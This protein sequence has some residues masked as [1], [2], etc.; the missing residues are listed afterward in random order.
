MGSGQAEKLRSNN[1]FKKT[2]KEY[3]KKWADPWAQKSR[4]KFFFYS[5]QYELKMPL[6]E[7]RLLSQ[8][9][10][11]PLAT[12]TCFWLPMGCAYDLSKLT[13]ERV[14]VLNRM[15]ASWDEDI[16]EVANPWIVRERLWLTIISLHVI[17]CSVYGALNWS[18]PQLYSLHSSLYSWKPHSF[19][20]Y[21]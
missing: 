8:R 12:P 4:F 2:I 10:L 7:S 9:T 17:G 11:D 13:C 5:C 15:V 14:Y 3:T 6:I 18:K 21:C 16:A 19:L 1:L 20:H